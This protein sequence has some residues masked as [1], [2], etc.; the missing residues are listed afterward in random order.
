MTVRVLRDGTLDFGLRGGGRL[1]IVG[2]GAAAASALS[3]RWLDVQRR[4]GR[5][6]TAGEIDRM[7][8]G[9]GARVK[10]FPAGGG[11]AMQYS[12]VVYGADRAGNV[13]LPRQPFEVDGADFAT[14][15]LAQADALRQAAEFCA[16]E[17][18]RRT[19]GAGEEAAGG[20]EAGAPPPTGGDVG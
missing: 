15:D 8:A 3:I 1:L 19:P 6:M 13:W 16:A 20:P 14:P 11:E 7:L 4:E 2:L 10:H 18:G 5:E 12:V 17:Q 9:T